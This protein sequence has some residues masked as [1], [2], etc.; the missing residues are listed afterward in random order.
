MCRR[1]ICW[2][3]NPSN[4]DVEERQNMSLSS[5]AD[6]GQH[7]A[8]KRAVYPGPSS[9]SVLEVL[10]GA[11]LALL[12]ERCNASDADPGPAPWHQCW[13]GRRHPSERVSFATFDVSSSASALKGDDRALKSSHV[14]TAART[15]TNLQE[16]PAA[17][18]FAIRNRATRPGGVA[19]AV[20][21]DMKLASCSTAAL[22]SHHVG[23]HVDA[24]HFGAT[25][26]DS[27][28]DTLGLRRALGNCSAGGGRVF[29]PAGH[30]IVSKDPL[31]LGKGMLDI[32]PVP[33]NCHVYGA[34][35]L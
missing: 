5:S 22:S 15:K 18:V 34:G 33:S 25:P 17:E 3:S 13:W 14:Y 35:Q 1:Q 10:P 8:H 27:T 2:L 30:Y 29:I 16:I 19:R 12:F 28:D 23:R 6:A 21:S 32:L 20:Y 9:Y 7:W 11:R 24:T 31:H 26:D 4:A